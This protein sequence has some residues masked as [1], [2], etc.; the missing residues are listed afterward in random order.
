M[1]AIGKISVKRI[2]EDTIVSD[3]SGQSYTFKGR[4]NR[5]PLE[6][7][8]RIDLT[9]PIYEQVMRLAVKDAAREKAR[10]AKRKRA[11]KVA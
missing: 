11:V 5:P 9:R 4:G 3:E 2:G 7:D 6:I 10:I 8:P 1:P